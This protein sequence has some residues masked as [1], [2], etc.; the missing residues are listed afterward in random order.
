MKNHG[1]WPLP[2]F[3]FCRIASEFKNCHCCR[4]E[5]LHNI[6]KAENNVSE[7]RILH[8]SIV[9]TH[10][11]QSNPMVESTEI[12][13][14]EWKIKATCALVAQLCSEFILASSVSEFEYICT[15][16]ISFVF[17]T[18]K[19]TTQFLPRIFPLPSLHTKFYHHKKPTQNDCPVLLVI[20]PPPL[21]IHSLPPIN[22][23]L[24]KTTLH[25]CVSIHLP[26]PSLPSQP[27]PSPPQKKN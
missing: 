17:P 25:P 24:N 6:R 2:T 26:F 5:I 7:C 18:K 13:L 8:K 4:L 16:K 20:R 9:H 19:K 14:V 10:S 27:S 23:R 1:H 15:W 3:Q 21:H 22:H 11:G 12:N